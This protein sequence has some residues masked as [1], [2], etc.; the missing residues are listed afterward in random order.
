MSNLT[1]STAHP[2]S[3]ETDTYEDTVA[4]P[5]RDEIIK[6]LKKPSVGGTLATMITFY[7]RRLHTHRPALIRL[8]TTF[9]P[10]ANTDQLLPAMGLPKRCSTDIMACTYYDVHAMLSMLKG[11]CSGSGGTRLTQADIAILTDIVEPAVEEMDV[12]ITTAMAEVNEER[13]DAAR[14]SLVKLSDVE[15]RRRFLEGG[16]TLPADPALRYCPHCKCKNTIDLPAENTA[17]MRRNEVRMR[18]WGEEKKQWEEAKAKG[19]V[20]I[21][22]GSKGQACGRAPK[23]PVMERLP[24]VCHCHQMRNPNP[25]DPDDPVSTCPI[26]CRDPKTGVAYKYDTVLRKVTCPSC[27]CN[28]TCAFEVCQ[29]YI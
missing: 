25:R 3:E 15:R 12:V 23:L 11:A 4:P 19:A 24:Y 18:E 6:K 10:T 8:L 2:S 13:M 5:S 29:H 21:R 14:S 22:V 9:I 7:N 20:P 17:R 27:L 16:G 1:S 28:C 26:K